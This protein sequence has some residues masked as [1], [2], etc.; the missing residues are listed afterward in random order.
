MGRIRPTRDI[1]FG[2]AG[3]R[4]QTD[5]DEF[6]LPALHRRTDGAGRGDRRARVSLG[7]VRPGRVRRLDLARAG[8][9]VRGLIRVPP[10]RR[11]DR[12]RHL[13]LRRPHDVG[14]VR[15]R[16]REL[17][18]MAAEEPELR[19][20]RLDAARALEQWVETCEQLR[21]RATPAVRAARC[22]PSRRTRRPQARRQA[23]SPRS[24]RSSPSGPRYATGA[25]RRR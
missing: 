7:A 11:V 20:Q 24:G 25:V 19:V 6:L 23:T 12:G 3:G 18:G 10:P 17:V 15:R 16:G 14:R 2:A 5:L 4:S 13:R 8:R 21:A 1:A 9:A 22:P